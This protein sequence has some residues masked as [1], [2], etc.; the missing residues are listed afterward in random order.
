MDEGADDDDAAEGAR[1]PVLLE[2]LCISFWRRAT[3]SAACAQEGCPA[4]AAG[5]LSEPILRARRRAG[6]GGCG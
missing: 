6:G 2:C 1:L 4:V 5:A 3:R